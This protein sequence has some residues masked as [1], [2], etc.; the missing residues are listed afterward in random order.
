MKKRNGKGGEK[1]KKMKIK[2]NK[3]KKIYKNKQFKRHKPVDDKLEG[4]SEPSFLEK[5]IDHI[6]PGEKNST[7]D[8]H[9][10]NE[11]QY[12]QEAFDIERVQDVLGTVLEAE[13]K[14]RE[15]DVD[16]DPAESREILD[17]EVEQVKKEEVMLLENVQKFST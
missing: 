16:D 12:H 10:L 14:A 8:D 6:V 13:E 9:E 2:P 7:R 4:Q 11:T 3:K 1:K 17:N 5:I 15:S